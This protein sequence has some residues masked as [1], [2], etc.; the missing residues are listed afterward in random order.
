MNVTTPT[1]TSVSSEPALCV[2]FELS[3]GKWK[4]AFSHGLGQRARIRTV[5]AGDLEGVR[6]EIAGAKRRF[7]LPAEV[8]V[9]SCYEAGRDGFWLHR[10]LQS[11]GIENL[12]VDSASIEVKRR[13]KKVK[14]DRLDA[15]KLLEMLLRYWLGE[16]R[17]W[18]TVR[19]PSQEEEDRR[20][21]HRELAS[22]KKDRTRIINRVK[23]LLAG[24]GIRVGGLNYLP[25]QVE[26]MRLWNGE[27]L[28]G[29]LKERLLREWD[30]LLF[31]RA[32]VKQLE[33]A[34]R[35][36]LRKLD[37]V[38]TQC[39]AKLMKLRSIGEDSSWLLS[40]EF[41][42]W[43]Q[44]K[45]GGQIGGLSGLTPTHYSSGND[46]RE[47]GISKAGSSAIRHTA[48][49]LAWSWLRYQPESELSQWY[50][51]KFGFGNSRLR[52]IGIVA[53]ARKLLIALWRYLETDA[54]PAGAVL[55]A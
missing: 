30:R 16:T 24:Q 36:Q 11:F 42:S 26:E 40:M 47:L 22:A 6:A 44:F 55:K 7:G 8:L 54:P 37:N 5:G 43:R 13:R 4:M 9:R 29:M 45:N 39:A 32:Q 49:E 3:A 28:P 15:V 34:R 51:Q 2:A 38:G 46:A 48:V 21:L 14:T 23:A 18:S 10:A 53:L 31:A 17:V 19:V 12:V 52:R 27:P 35:E 20:H 25:Q 33:T 1:Q 41:F 50:Q